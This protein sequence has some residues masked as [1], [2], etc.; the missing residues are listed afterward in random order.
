MESS[1]RDRLNNMADHRT[2]L[3]NDQNTYNPRFIFT[4]QTRWATKNWH[5]FCFYCASELAAGRNT[6]RSI[7]LAD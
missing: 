6:L 7:H 4:L 3:K 2:T 1:H 5:L